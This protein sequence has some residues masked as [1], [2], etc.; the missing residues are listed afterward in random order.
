MTELIDVPLLGG[1]V[2]V[3][4]ARDLERTAAG[5]LPHRLPARARAQLHDPHFR[6]VEA[7]PAGVRLVF[8]TAATVLRWRCWRPRRSCPATRPSAP[9][10]APARRR[11]AP[12]RRPR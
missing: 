3:R 7:Q 1:P 8:R 11:R 10:P 12:P 5:L 6:M 4:G 2:A 9:G